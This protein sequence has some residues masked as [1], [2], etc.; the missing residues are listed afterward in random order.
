MQIDKIFI[1][2]WL[3]GLSEHLELCSIKHGNQSKLA[4]DVNLAECDIS[5]VKNKRYHEISKKRILELAIKTSYDCDRNPRI[6][7]I[8]DSLNADQW[9]E[10]AK[11]FIVIP[12]KEPV[13]IPDNILETDLPAPIPSQTET[14]TSEVKT[15]VPLDVRM[16]KE[17]L[18]YRR[19]E[20]SPNETMR[21]TF[22]YGLMHRLIKNLE[23]LKEQDLC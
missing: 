18:L 21:R 14:K 4:K 16:I 20:N 8:V 1:G 3:N 23:T 22:R 11:E 9:K 2:D 17:Y 6:S 7:Q 10:L 15:V 12:V 13:N 5:N 19:M